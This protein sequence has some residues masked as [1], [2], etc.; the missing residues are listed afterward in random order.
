[1]GLYG[2]HER[3]Y[4]QCSTARPSTVVQEADRRPARERTESLK[5]GC[6]RHA[7]GFTGGLTGGFTEM[8]T[9]G[10]QESTQGH[11]WA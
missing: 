9:V 7:R 4:M 11:T 1:M 2:L 8:S 3:P 6:E 10:A 5:R